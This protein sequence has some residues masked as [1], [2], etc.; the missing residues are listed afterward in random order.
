MLSNCLHGTLR[1]IVSWVAWRSGNALLG[2]CQDNHSWFLGSTHHTVGKGRQTI[3]IA[4]R[5]GDQCFLE[6]LRV[7]VLPEGLS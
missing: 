7:T 6:G 2:S 5:V 4:E 3:C 1:G